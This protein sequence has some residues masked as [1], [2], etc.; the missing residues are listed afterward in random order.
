M[1]NAGTLP[2]R[3]LGWEMTSPPVTAGTTRSS[4][5][6]ASQRYPGATG[7]GKQSRPPPPGSVRPPDNGP[8]PAWFNGGIYASLDALRGAHDWSRRCPSWTSRASSADTALR[9]LPPHENGTS[10]AAT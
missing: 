4:A 2:P 5:A 6:A 8:P 10:T 1:V 7:R 9:L 3:C